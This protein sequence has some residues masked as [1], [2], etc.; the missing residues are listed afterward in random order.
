MQA[1]PQ[2]AWQKPFL[3]DMNAGPW[4]EFQALK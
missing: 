1:H 3:H 2:F 4:T